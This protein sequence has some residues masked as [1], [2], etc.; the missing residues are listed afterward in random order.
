[1][2]SD[3]QMLAVARAHRAALADL[4][5]LLPLYI[6]VPQDRRRVVHLVQYLVVNQ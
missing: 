4:V 1:M 6:F 5:H 3:E 2:P